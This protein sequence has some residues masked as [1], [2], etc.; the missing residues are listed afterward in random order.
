MSNYLIQVRF[1][2]A[3]LK[4]EFPLSGV[5]LAFAFQREWI[6]GQGLVEVLAWWWGMG[7]LLNSTEQE[8]AGLFPNELWRLPKLLDKSKSLDVEKDEQKIKHL[9]LYLILAWLFENRHKISDPLGEI[10]K[11]YADFNYPEEIQG[12]VRYMPAEDGPVGEEGII[13]RWREYVTKTKT[14]FLSERGHY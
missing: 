2:A 5:E 3:F 9:W 1:P 10:E 11:L 4:L 12:L 8:I 7:M 14:K 6:S 13:S